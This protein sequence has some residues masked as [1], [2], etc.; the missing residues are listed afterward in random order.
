MKSVTV[1]K[2]RLERGKD[3]LQFSGSFGSEDLSP[4]GI[5]DVNVSL[6]GGSVPSRVGPAFEG[7]D[8][9]YA[10]QADEARIGG[11]VFRDLAFAA[12]RKGQAA[13]FSL[14]LRPPQSD[15]DSGLAAQGFSGEAGSQSG[16]PLVKAEG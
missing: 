8:G 11:V 13:D 10:A 15:A 9:E 14:S 16:S 7:H 2:A 6:A 12:A 5:L 1:E 3:G 4:D